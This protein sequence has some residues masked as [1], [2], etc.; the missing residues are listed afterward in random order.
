MKKVFYVGVF[1]LLLGLLGLLALDFPLLDR[2]SLTLI[3]PEGTPLSATYN[4]H[5]HKLRFPAFEKPHF[6]TALGI[7]SGFRFEGRSPARGL[8]LG[9][10]HAAQSCPRPDRLRLARFHL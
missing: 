7:L 10:A 3:S 4:A 2:Q 6:V 9:S 1:L 8:W 5:G